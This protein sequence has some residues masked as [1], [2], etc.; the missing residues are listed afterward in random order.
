MCRSGR[1]GPRAR[2]MSCS[3]C[4]SL[5]C[6]SS[7]GSTPVSVTLPINFYGMVTIPPIVAA[8]RGLAGTT[9]DI[10]TLVSYVLLGVVGLHVLADA[11]SSCLAARPRLP[12]H[13]A[14]QPLADA[15]SQT[16]T[17]ADLSPARRRLAFYVLL[18]GALMPSLN[19]F[20]VTIALPAIRDA[21]HASDRDQPHHRRL[22]LGLC[23]LPRDRRP[24]RRSLRPPP[25]VHHRHG[26]IHPD[27]AALRPRAG[28]PGAGD[29]AH[30]PGHLRA[31]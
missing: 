7:A 6:R 16:A 14:G 29:R 5:S 13:A 28:C 11:L 27:L 25:H 24:A 19:I 4:C 26:R 1:I 10:H 8:S 22:F 17:L 20:I 15:M 31:R 12:A 3:I 23:G 21:L 18:L 9:G 30:L 2:R